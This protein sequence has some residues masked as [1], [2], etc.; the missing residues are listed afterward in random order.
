MRQT[1]PQLRGYRFHRQDLLTHPF[2]HPYTKI[3]FM[4]W[5]LNVSC[6]TAATYLNRLAQ[7][8]G[9]LQ[10]CKQGKPITRSIIR[11][12]NCSRKWRSP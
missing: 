4:Q 10:K 6:L 9:R 1:Q 2:R 5:E 12:P 3:E 11:C 8:D 7:P